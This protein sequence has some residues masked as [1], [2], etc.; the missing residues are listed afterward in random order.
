MGW[1]QMD[2]GNYL[3][4]VCKDALEYTMKEKFGKVWDGEKWVP[5]KR[6]D[7]L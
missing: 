2:I 1:W 4:R 6:N 3:M 5:I 7:T